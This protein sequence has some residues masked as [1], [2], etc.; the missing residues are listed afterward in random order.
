MIMTRLVKGAKT[1]FGWCIVCDDFSIIIPPKAWQR[2]GFVAGEEAVFIPGSKKS[3][4]FSISSPELMAE[5]RKKMGG[6]GLHEIGKA[7]FGDGRVLLPPEI[8]FQP[9]DWLLTVLGSCYGLGF[10][11]QG[12]IFQEAV[13]NGIL[14][15]FMQE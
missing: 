1:T 10:I 7:T 11:S 9:G 4:G 2:Y 12:P 13:E 6:A 5:A 3:G 14:E 15:V 8:N